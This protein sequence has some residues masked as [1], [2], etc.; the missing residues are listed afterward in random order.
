MAPSALKWLQ[1]LLLLAPLTA[2]AQSSAA[3][4][5][6]ATTSFRAIFTV[7]SNADVGKTLIANIDDPQAKDAQSLC[8][9]YKASNAKVSASGLTAD[10]T[11]AGP[12]C[13]VYGTDVDSLSLS[14]EYQT[15]Q[16]LHVNIVP[17]HTDAKNESFYILSPDYVPAGK[18]E[19]GK[20]DGSDLTFSWS[21]DP[22][23]NFE[24]VRHETG[25]VLFSTKGSVL[26]FEDQFLEFV[27]QEPADYNVYGLGETVRALRLGNNYT[28]TMYAADVGD[29]I[30]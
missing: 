20:A 17:S 11:L 27:T 15:D 19:D 16:R 3:T 10:L 12:A 7:P 30:D 25:D 23:F 18:Q 26:V 24:V 22:S 21:N 14:V 28:K 4:G 9:G 5:A 8:P 6:S 29:P 2:Y 13:N 1:S